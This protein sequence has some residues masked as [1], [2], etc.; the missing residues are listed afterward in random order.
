MGEAKKAFQ[1]ERIVHY[2]KV[3]GRVNGYLG[4]SPVLAT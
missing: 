2:G 1:Q 4:R 3:D